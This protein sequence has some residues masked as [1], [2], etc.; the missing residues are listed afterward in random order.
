MLD[1]A[2]NLR[3]DYIKKDLNFL[4]ID[5]SP[6]DDGIIDKNTQ[7]LIKLINNTNISAQ[8]KD[9]SDDIIQKGA[10][11]FLY[12]NPYIR[13][14]V[15]NYWTEFYNNFF[16]SLPSSKK[17][18]SLSKIVNN[19]KSKDSQEIANKILVWLSKELGFKY[20]RPELSKDGILNQIIWKNNIG[21]IQGI[22]TFLRHK[23][24]A[25]PFLLQSP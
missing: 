20:F 10:K 12:I 7:K 8:F 9:H 22:C 16:R 21:N 18:L 1:F 19:K 15:L 23:T 11:M 24:R 17:V 25:P 3:K 5:Y 2:R 13:G 6:T 14:S 4:Y